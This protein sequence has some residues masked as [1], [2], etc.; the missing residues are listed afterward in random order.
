[1]GERGRAL[2]Q[3]QGRLAREYRTVCGWVGLRSGAMAACDAIDAN[4]K[5]SSGD[6]DDVE[7]ERLLGGAV[8]DLFS[9]YPLIATIRSL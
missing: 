5:G 1:M 7:R 9:L 6:G 4:L 2:S 3:D 8:K